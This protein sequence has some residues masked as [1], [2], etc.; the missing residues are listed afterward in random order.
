MAR[1]GD[2]IAGRYTLCELFTLGG[3][4]VVWRARDEQLGRDV[5]LKS[6]HSGDGVARLRTAARN[7][8]CL[9]HPNIVGVHDIFV[10][11][12]VW[13]LVTEY[14]P[15][16]SLAEL[17]R[18]APEL[19]RARVVTVGEQIAGALAHSHDR[20]IVHCDL[21]PENIIVTDG[22]E[23]RL[24]DFGSSVDL[25]S[26]NTGETPELDSPPG[27]WRYLAPELVR[28]APVSPKSDVFALG[29]S[30]LAVAEGRGTAG[31]R[32]M[33]LAQLTASDPNH[34]PSAAVAA[35][36]FA[37]LERLPRGWDRAVLR[38]TLL[39][40]AEL[41]AL[42]LLVAAAVAVPAPLSAD[43]VANPRTADPCALL[44][45]AVLARYGR[46]D[47]DTDSGN[48]DTCDLRVRLWGG[49]EHPDIGRIR[50]RL[51]VAAPEPTSQVAVSRTGNIS[52]ISEPAGSARCVRSLELAGGATV[53]IVGERTAASGPDACT[54]ADT[55]A[56][57]VRELLRK[58]PIPRRPG[59][60]PANSLAHHDACAQ[61]DPV[62]LGRVAGID[63]LHP[64][65]GWAGWSCRWNSTIDGH[66]TVRYD[67]DAPKTAASGR[68]LTLAGL[69]AFRREGVKARDDCTVQIEYRHFRGP[70]DIDRVEVVVVSFTGSHSPQQRCETA[71]D[72]ATVVAA[73][74]TR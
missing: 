24:T 8:A 14:V 56:T 15:G 44:D 21:S 55:V 12:G 61:L 33:L 46:I 19:A 57:R 38:R 34:R 30:L 73:N 40:A 41:V 7:A 26:A 62:T 74:L 22:G 71:T 2:T 4:G 6:P 16:R 39:A 64:V 65:A 37:E 58:G 27:K 48:F 67:R 63:A 70:S 29:A 69:A 17:A 42:A 53:E 28:G 9:R 5:V 66:V 3:E 72:L 43:F 45:P 36:R 1:V 25:H 23:A 68:P 31:R 51:S 11:A 47:L 20:G 10:D 52:V 49:D 35:T 60:F 59:P 18:A 54:L 50:L 32:E 13:W